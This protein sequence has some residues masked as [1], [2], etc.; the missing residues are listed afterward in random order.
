[1]AYC[2]KCGKP[3]AEGAA[4]CSFCGTAVSDESAQRK[5]VFVGSIRKCPNCGE[6]IGTDTTKCPSCGFVIEKKNVSSALDV[7][8]KKFLSL[9]N[10]S[11]KR[12]YIESYAIANNKEDIRDFLNYAASQRDKAYSDNQT[13]AFWVDAW[14]N[15]CRQIVN[16]AFDTFG[17]DEDFSAW[18]KNYKQDVEKTSTENEKLKKKLISIE[19]GKKRAKAAKVFLKWFG[20][21]VLGLALL[22]GAG[23][24]IRSCSIKAAENS[25]IRAEKKLEMQKLKAQQEK[26]EREREEQRQKEEQEREA[27]KQKEE[28]ERIERQ[29]QEE[30]ARKK[31]EQ[32]RAE[33]QR[34]KEEA[35][36]K[37]EKE[38]E[39]RLKKLEEEKQKQEEQKAAERQKLI[40]GCVIPKENIQLTGFVADH[41]IAVSDCTINLILKEC[42]GFSN[43]GFGCVKHSISFKIK[44]TDDV[45]S[46]VK[47]T[48]KETEYDEAELW[49]SFLQT[50]YGKYA[51]NNA[52]MRQIANANKG[53]VITIIFDT[54]NNEISRLKK[55]KELDEALIQLHSSGLFTFQATF[56]YKMYY[57]GTYGQEK[58]Y[59]NFF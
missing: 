44:A 24:G 52:I 59:I 49:S 58:K 41:F 53:D 30:E 43:L 2:N 25:K 32:E 5:Q 54:E 51:S 15:K 47:K 50:N 28:Q 31:A 34:Q 9:K 42:A 7:F 3:L 33:Q 38:E 35:R 17:A 14:N 1:M 8:I 40:N 22:F 20:I 4:F 29:R 13:K 45:S 57:Q 27:Q 55:E 19:N 56:T 26:E 16:Q 39:E 23:Y 6:Q 36:K 46:F 12:E 10:S 37:A 48:L 11:E 18:L 21:G